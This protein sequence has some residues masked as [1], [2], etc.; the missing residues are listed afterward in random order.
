MLNI[1]TWHY[2]HLFPQEYLLAGADFIETNTFSGTW[3]AQADYS[4]EKMVISFSV[5]MFTILVGI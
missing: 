4:M 5:K 1:Y 3:V 2:F